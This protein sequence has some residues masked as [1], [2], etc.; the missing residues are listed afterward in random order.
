MSRLFNE[1]ALPVIA[2]AFDPD[3][4][5]PELSPDF[6]SSPEQFSCGQVYLSSGSASTARLRRSLP[7]PPVS[8]S[9]D[10]LGY[11][12][13]DLNETELLYDYNDSHPVNSTL[14]LRSARTRT[15]EGT[16]APDPQPTFFP[17]WDYFAALPNLT[18]KE[19]H[20]LRIVGG[21]EAFPGQL[22]WQVWRVECGSVMP[23]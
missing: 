21:Q 10:D 22:P 23:T 15:V 9:D 2:C 12:Y 19:N 11:D 13:G 6:L 7:P 18:A 3:V 16:G 8:E 20:N 5:H 17:L 1:A 4:R 14:N